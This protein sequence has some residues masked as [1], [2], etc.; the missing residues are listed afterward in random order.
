MAALTTEDHSKRGED[1]LFAARGAGTALARQNAART[2]YTA[3]RALGLRLKFRALVRLEIMRIVK[4]VAEAFAKLR[5]F[6]FILNDL[7]VNS[8][9]RCRIIG[10]SLL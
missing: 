1:K 2:Y 8:L 5:L 9:V 10:C 4:A 6:G 7:L 3:L